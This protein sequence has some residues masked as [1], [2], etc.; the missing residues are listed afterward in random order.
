MLCST[1]RMLDTP[2][3]VSHSEFHEDVILSLRGVTA[4]YLRHT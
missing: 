3:R 1:I 2:S 4:A